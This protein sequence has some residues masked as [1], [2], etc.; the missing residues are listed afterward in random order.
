MNI[1][2]KKSPPYKSVSVE[3]DSTVI[4]LG[5][6]NQAEQVE[7]AKM[8]IASAQQLLTKEEFDFLVRG[9]YPQN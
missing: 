7:F 9:E 6:M 2:I 5:L 3:A 1:N 4:N 8:L